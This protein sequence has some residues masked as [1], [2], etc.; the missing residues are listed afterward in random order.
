MKKFIP[1]TQT[2]NQ[3][4]SYFIDSEVFVKKD[5]DVERGAN[6]ASTLAALDHPFIQQYIKSYEEDG[7]HVLET[8][9]F[10]GDTLENLPKL[11][12]AEVDLIGSQLLNVLSYT[13][14]VNI[15]HGD[16]NVSNV[17]FDGKNILVIDWET[18]RSGDAMNDLFGVHSHQG[19]LNTIKLIRRKIYG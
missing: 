14:R 13:I 11:T 7:S 5:I 18:A 9:F 3:D 16:I 1:N 4:R 17:L 10:K 8:E 19:I 6:E 2:V 15:I 12:K